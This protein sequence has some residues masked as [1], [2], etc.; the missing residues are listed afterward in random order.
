MQFIDLM[1]LV[2]MKGSSDDMSTKYTSQYLTTLR[3][4]D[5]VPRMILGEV[6]KKLLMRISKEAMLNQTCPFNHCSSYTCRLQNVLTR[7]V[8]IIA[9]KCEGAY[10]YYKRSVIDRNFDSRNLINNAL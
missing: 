4:N 7:S 6:A 10:R 3:E 5:A 9:V 1:Y 8:N 2:H